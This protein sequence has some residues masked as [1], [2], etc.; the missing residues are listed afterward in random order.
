MRKL[1]NLMEYNKKY[2]VQKESYKFM[3][4]YEIG[5]MITRFEIQFVYET[6]TKYVYTF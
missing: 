6:L 2:R 3:A 5:K 4:F 1:T